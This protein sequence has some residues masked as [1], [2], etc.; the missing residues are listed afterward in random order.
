MSQ[1]IAVEPTSVQ[2]LLDA[3]QFERQQQ[4]P[5]DWLEANADLRMRLEHTADRT[6]FV[7]VGDRFPAF[8]LPTSEG[9]RVRLDVLLRTGPVVLTM[10]RFESCP[11][12]NITLAGYQQSLVEPLRLLGA[13]LVAVS[14]QAA[15]RLRRLQ[16]RHG[17]DFFLASDPDAALITAAGVGFAPAPA[18]QERAR[19]VG[20]DLGAVLG[21]GGWTLP[22]PTVVVIDRD[23]IVR[24]ADVHPDWMVRTEPAAVIEAVRSLPPS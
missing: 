7:K 13:H 24:F 8:D 5:A 19:C 6:R 2:D 23:G 14:P 1:T 10:F 17:L 22:H 3:L 20:D 16:D 4:W 9:G 18:D 12:C 15:S 21:T 11:S